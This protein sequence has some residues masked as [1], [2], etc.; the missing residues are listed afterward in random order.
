M[1]GTM[2]T[3]T[4]C[5]KKENCYRFTAKSN[6]YRQAYFTKPPIKDG[7]CEMYW[8]KEAE[9]IMNQLKEIMK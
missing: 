3:G 9:F 8:G 5:P 1:D 7:K 6:E 4:D 2:C